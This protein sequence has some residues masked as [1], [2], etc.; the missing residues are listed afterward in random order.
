MPMIDANAGCARNPMTLAHQ[1][2]YGHTTNGCIPA[3]DS[4]GS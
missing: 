1:C 3:P 4:R 2:P